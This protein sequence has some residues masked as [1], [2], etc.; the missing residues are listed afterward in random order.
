[1]GIIGIDDERDPLAHQGVGDG[2]NLN[3][4]CVGDLFDTDDYKHEK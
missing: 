3:L 1:M 2:V 4:G